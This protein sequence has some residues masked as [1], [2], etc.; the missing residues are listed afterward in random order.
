MNRAG[1]PY[2]RSNPSCFGCIIWPAFAGLIPEQLDDEA[3]K[4]VAELEAFICAQNRTIRPY[5][6][7]SGITRSAQS[8]TAQG[9]KSK[10]W[11]QKSNRRNG[12][13]LRPILLSMSTTKGSS[14]DGTRQWRRLDPTIQRYAAFGESK[15]L[16]NF[17]AS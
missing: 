2:N 14:P 4:R 10:S 9:L 12:S 11:D 6:T 8:T 17:V 13:S 16:R 7:S 5:S 1:F 3:S 15:S